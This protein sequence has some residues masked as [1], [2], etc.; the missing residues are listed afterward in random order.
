MCVVCSLHL[1]FCFLYYFHLV[2]KY[3]HITFY[4]TICTIRYD[5]HI[6]LPILKITPLLYWIII[7]QVRRSKFEIFQSMDFLFAPERNR[8]VTASYFPGSKGNVVFSAEGAVSHFQFAAVDFCT[9]SRIVPVLPGA[10]WEIQQNDWLGDSPVILLSSLMPPIRFP[11]Y[12]P[13][14]K[15]FVL[16]LV[17]GVIPN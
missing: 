3:S 5:S 9:I 12:R 6:I 15:G 13:D 2:H 4:I 14:I 8:K 7:L 10:K 11:V 17:F 16:M 1:Q